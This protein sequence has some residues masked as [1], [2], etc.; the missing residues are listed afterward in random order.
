MP[1]DA[2]RYEIGTE[3]QL[4]GTAGLAVV[5]V[6][7]I[8]PRYMLVRLAE[9]PDAEP[10]GISPDAAT[11][12]PSLEEIRAATAAIRAEWTPDEWQRRRVGPDVIE[13]NVPTAAPAYNAD[14]RRRTNAS[15]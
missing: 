9:Q 5:V 4:N 14:A 6:E 1:A 13:W 10:F 8:T 3:L 15:A 12:L 2:R 7:I 11:W